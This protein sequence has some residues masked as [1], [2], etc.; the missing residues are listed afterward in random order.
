M[1]KISAFLLA[2]ALF[3]P[4]LSVRSQE[5]IRDENGIPGS[6]GKT[7]GGEYRAFSVEED[8][9]QN[10]NATMTAPTA[11]TTVVGAAGAELS[12]ES[13]QDDAITE[14]QAILAKILAAPSTEAKQDDLNALIVII[15]AVLD[16]IKTDTANISSDQAT[17]TTLAAVLAKLIA[18][19]ATEA[20]QDTG[21]TSLATIAGLDFSTETTL[22]AVLAKIIA[23]PSTEAKQDSAITELQSILAKIIAAPATEAKQD[24]GNTSLA[25][26][27]GLDFSTETTLAAVLAKIIAAPATEAK[28]DDNI[29]QVTDIEL[30]TDTGT[31][32]GE[33]F[34]VSCAGTATVID[35]VD[36]GRR[37]LIMQNAANSTIYIGGP[38]VTTSIGLILIGGN[39]AADGKGGILIMDSTGA[40]SCITDGG[41]EILRVWE[42]KD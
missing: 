4:A 35:G 14:L 3:V 21:N 13:K 2:V 18:A 30:N 25:T 23:A 36:T 9:T 20:K 8:G 31:G 34:T 15:D 38:A 37:E 5:A 33:P 40:M 41:T 22:A 7:S 42:L 32:L 17:E 39:A 6:G 27:A 12:K 24:T 16:A 11:P 28:Q 19:P 26:I 29:T 1:K 10:V